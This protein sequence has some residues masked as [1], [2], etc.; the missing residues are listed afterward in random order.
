MHPHILRENLSFFLIR[1]LTKIYHFQKPP[2]DFVND[3][4][5]I[6]ARVK[7]VENDNIAPLHYKLLLHKIVENVN[8]RAHAKNH[9]VESTIEHVLHFLVEPRSH[10]LLDV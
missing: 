1:N 2:G 6:A 10:E 8:F 3:F 4:F 9:K 5:H 7:P